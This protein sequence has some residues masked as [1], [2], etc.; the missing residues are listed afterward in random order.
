MLS[1]RVR[2][3]PLGHRRIGACPRGAPPETCARVCTYWGVPSLPHIFWLPANPLA[4]GMAF[5]LYIMEGRE[6]TGAER[7]GRTSATQKVLTNRTERGI[8]LGDGYSVRG[9][10]W[11]SRGQTASAT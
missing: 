1:C 10:C 3:S 6:G 5:G 9:H 7:K 11:S 2:P 8:M 4:E